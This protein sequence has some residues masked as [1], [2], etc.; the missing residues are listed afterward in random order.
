MVAHRAFHH[1]KRPA[2]NSAAVKT[3]GAPHTATCQFH[4][5]MRFL[6]FQA[7]W[8]YGKTLFALLAQSAGG[9]LGEYSLS[10]HG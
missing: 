3:Y 9:T 8:A 2:Q 6:R 4:A 10:T 7:P 5:E 1:W